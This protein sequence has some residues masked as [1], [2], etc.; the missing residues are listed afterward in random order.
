MSKNIDDADNQ[1][2]IDGWYSDLKQHHS[3][4][5]SNMYTDAARTT[6][7]YQSSAS[8]TMKS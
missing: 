4:Q 7:S 5:K 3:S 8:C 2:D 6:S 1:A